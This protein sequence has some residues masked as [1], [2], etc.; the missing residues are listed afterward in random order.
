MI[1]SPPIARVCTQA[2]AR[3]HVVS[4]LPFSLAVLRRF[5]KFFP[6][7][8]H[9]EIWQRIQHITHS[10]CIWRRR[11]V[12][13]LFFSLKE[14]LLREKKSWK[15]PGLVMKHAATTRMPIARGQAAASVV[16]VVIHVFLMLHGGGPKLAAVLVSFQVNAML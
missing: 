10:E 13:A 14:I 16:V 8:A 11:K 12:M 15:A 5:P 1:L 3:G 7:S 9:N 2:Q 6:S 4:S